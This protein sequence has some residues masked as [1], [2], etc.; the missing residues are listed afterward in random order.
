MD[1]DRSSI[2]C[3]PFSTDIFCK[4]IKKIWWRLKSWLIRSNNG[5]NAKPISSNQSEK[6]EGQSICCS[7]NL[8]QNLTR[9]A[10]QTGTARFDD[11]FANRLH[12]DRE[13]GESEERSRFRSRDII[14]TKMLR[15][16]CTFRIARI[17]YLV[18]PQSDPSITTSL[19]GWTSIWNWLLSTKKIIWNCK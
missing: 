6:L 8:P 17:R 14:V 15:I 12:D 3:N 7:A 10:N 5:S 13:K 4:M 18:K 16:I 9:K 1:S 19:R 11:I 2:I